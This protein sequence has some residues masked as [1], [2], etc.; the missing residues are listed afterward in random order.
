MSSNVG[1]TELVMS[2]RCRVI[3]EA[4]QMGESW[5]DKLSASLDFDVHHR[6]RR[7]PR[8]FAVGRHYRPLLQYV[9]DAA[10][11]GTVYLPVSC[12]TNSAAVDLQPTKC[13]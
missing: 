4:S 2:N 11:R 10:D 12:Q 5:K 8:R 6:L 7:L 13:H 1:D 3:R 9:S